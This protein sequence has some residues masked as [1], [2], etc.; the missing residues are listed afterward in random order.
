MVKATLN[1]L[2]P[3]EEKPVYYQYPPPP[4]TSWRNTHGDR[5]TLPIH[6]ARSL[7]PKPSLDAQGFE[8]APLRT[9]LEDLYDAEAVRRTYYPE[10]EAL[11]QKRTGATRV[12]A[13]DHNVRSEELAGRKERGA[14]HPVL[15]AH[16]DY[17]ERSSPQRVRDLLP[18]DD[19]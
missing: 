6:D 16:N 9:A 12:L 14:Q 7:D 8:L 13:F 3:M 15:Y 17:T 11:V 4:G 19:A 18:A 2:A 10:V 5:R 1:Y